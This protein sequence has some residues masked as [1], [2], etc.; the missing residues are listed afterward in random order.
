MASFLYFFLLAPI[1]CTATDLKPW[2]G[3]EY[4]T[5]IRASLLYQNYK[6]LDIPSHREFK[7]NENDYFATLSATYPFRRYSGEF[8][9]TAA[10]TKHQRRRWDNFRVTG[11]YQ[12]WNDEFDGDP[13]SIVTSITLTQAMGRALHD[14]SSFH[15]GHIEGEF[16]FSF[17]KKYGYPC[18]KDFVFRWWGVAGIATSDR[19]SPWARGDAACEYNYSDMHLFRLFLNSLWG[20]GG[21]DIR[22]RH[23]FKGYG[24]IAHRSVDVGIRYSLNWGW[25]GTLSLQYARRVHARNF[26]KN[27]NLV[28]IEYYYPFGSQ[29]PIRYCGY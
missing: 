12:W 20:M 14:V 7:R 25:W 27:A 19:G 8:E 4:E 29:D 18:S 1:V 28:F 11:R 22:P 10:F 24:K 21:Y 13:F 3:N 9:A 15:H 5:E 16:D 23:H 2:F 26:P 6:Y 17:G